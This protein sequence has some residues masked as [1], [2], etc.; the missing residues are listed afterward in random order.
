VSSSFSKPRVARLDESYCVIRD[1]YSR[2]I[3]CII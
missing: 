2:C 3:W 1:I